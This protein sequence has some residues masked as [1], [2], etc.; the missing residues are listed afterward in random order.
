MRLLAKFLRLRAAERW[1]VL[2]AFCRVLKASLRVHVFPYRKPAAGAKAVAAVASGRVGIS[3]ENIA[4][5]VCAVGRRIPGA[6]CL[7]QAL[8]AEEMLLR[9]GHPAE[10]RFGAAKEAG[11]VFV[12]HA[13]VVSGGKVLV[14]GESESRYLSLTGPAHK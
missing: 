14:G 8:A 7:V 1:L 9:H 12:A 4:W 6:T 2:E 13:W 10:I 3:S 11:K 5:A